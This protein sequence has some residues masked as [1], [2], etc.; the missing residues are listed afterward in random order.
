MA[1]WHLLVADFAFFHKCPRWQ[2]IRSFVVNAHTPILFSGLRLARYGFSFRTMYFSRIRSI[3]NYTTNDIRIPSP[4]WLSW[5][6]INTNAYRMF[7][8]SYIQHVLQSLLRTRPDGI[9]IFH[10]FSSGFSLDV[11]YF[12]WLKQRRYQI[13]VKKYHFLGRTSTATKYDTF[14]IIYTKRRQDVLQS[15][16]PNIVKSAWYC[17]LSNSS[18]HSSDRGFIVNVFVSEETVYLYIF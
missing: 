12:S 3:T 8:C 10:G 7:S 1:C 15:F 2:Y 18:C 4:T 11:Q 17:V 16:P 5:Q 9:A 6:S 13:H 14:F